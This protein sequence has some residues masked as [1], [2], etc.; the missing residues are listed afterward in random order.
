MYT[1]TSVTTAPAS[2][3]AKK[4]ASRA[5][6]FPRWWWPLWWPLRAAIAG[7]LEEGKQLLEK[8]EFAAAAKVFAGR[9][10]NSATR[11]PAFI[12]PAWFELGVGFTPDM[13]KARALYIAAAEKGSAAAINRLGLM[14]LRGEQVRQ[15]YAAASDLI[16]KAAGLNNSEA[17]VQLRHLGAGRHGPKEG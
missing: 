1:F 8:K 14:H 11:S 13:V 10:R 12:W 17:P 5:A 2:A 16:C 15:D 4:S 3:D 9:V 7:K 6:P